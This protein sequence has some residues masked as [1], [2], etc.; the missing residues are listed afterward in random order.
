MTNEEA[1]PTRHTTFFTLQ[2]ID[3]RA[4]V[5]RSCGAAIRW[6]VTER[7]KKTPLN[8]AAELHPLQAGGYEVSSDHSHWATCKNAGAHRRAKRA[9]SEDID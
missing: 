6:A 2:S 3:G 8:A 5:C 1:K 9:P 7:G 4:T